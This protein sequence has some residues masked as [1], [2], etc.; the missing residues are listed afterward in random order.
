MISLNGLFIFN[1]DIPAKLNAVELS[2]LR[3]Q[4]VSLS[5]SV[6]TGTNLFLKKVLPTELLQT[7][8]QVLVHLYLIQCL[9][10][11]DVDKEF[12]LAFPTRIVL[13]K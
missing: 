7:L 4:K 9:T 13:G 1:C 3:T 2:M 11:L 10:L 8:F 5:K 12:S 6:Y